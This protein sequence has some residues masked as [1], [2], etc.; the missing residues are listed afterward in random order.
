MDRRKPDK[1][2]LKITEIEAKVV[3]KLR[4]LIVQDCLD[5]CKTSHPWCPFLKSTKICQTIL[6][7]LKEEIPLILQERSQSK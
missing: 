3:T 2:D 5:E 4:H 7:T 6:D 1:I